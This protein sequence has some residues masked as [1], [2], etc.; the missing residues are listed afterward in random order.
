MASH[1]LYKNHELK[2]DRKEVKNETIMKV[3][4]TPYSDFGVRYFVTSKTQFSGTCM[5]I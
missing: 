2:Y 5:E 1:L 4:T 3:S